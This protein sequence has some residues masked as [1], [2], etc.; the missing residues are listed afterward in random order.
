MFLV[1]ANKVIFKESIIVDIDNICGV[2]DLNFSIECVWEYSC[3][4]SKGFSWLNH[5][6]IGELISFIFF[7]FT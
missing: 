7:L 2:P 4:K 6:L 3:L 1:P 5:P